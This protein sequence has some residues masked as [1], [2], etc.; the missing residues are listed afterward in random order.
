MVARS[1]GTERLW[2]LRQEKK[3]QK[4]KEGQERKGKEKEV[5]CVTIVYVVGL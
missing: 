2:S 4:G 3:G 1:N 5:D